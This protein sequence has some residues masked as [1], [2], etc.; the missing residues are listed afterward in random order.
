MTQSEFNNCLHLKPADFEYPDMLNPQ[1]VLRLDQFISIMGIR[2][3]ILSDY[4]P[5][6]ERQH[7]LG[8]A[9]DTYWDADPL[10][11]WDK[12]R[13]S[14]LFSGLGI[15]INQLGKVSFHFD[16]RPDRSPSSPALWGDTISYKYDPEKGEHV[17]ED[18]YT[19]AA[20]IIDV[21]KKNSG[22]GVMVALLLLGIYLLYKH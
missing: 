2:P 10:I 3:V 16:V 19:T 20:A 11:V 15:Y 22:S 5:D 12:A 8:N 6:D 13:G 18:E 4:R 1:V 9:I 21:I 17:R 14:Q 7:G